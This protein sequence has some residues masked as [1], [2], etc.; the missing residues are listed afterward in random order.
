MKKLLLAL[1]S[2]ISQKISLIHAPW[3][4]KLITGADYRT[5]SSLVQV[6]DV[7]STET[8]GELSNLFI[9]GFFGH[10]AIVASPRTVI[11]ATT[12][13]VVETDLAEFFFVNKDYIVASR[14]IFATPE[15]RQVA[16][17]YARAQLGKPYNFSMGLSDKLL[18]ALGMTVP[19]NKP[20]FAASDIQRFYCSELIYSA[21]LF[22]V[23]V[24]PF[25]LRKVLG[26][27]TIAPS[28]FFEATDK[29]DTFWFSESFKKKFGK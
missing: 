14:P 21:Y 10:V 19:D 27:E 28:D 25:T 12:H 15:Q 9:P 23:D 6:G 20:D 24:N 29:F 2:F 4:R 5:Y 3:T 17:D 1:A 18:K 8:N 22:A 13:G 11:Q 16:A 7:L 26:E